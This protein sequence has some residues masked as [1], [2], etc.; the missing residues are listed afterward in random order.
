[1]KSEK[2]KVKN[3]AGRPA[4]LRLSFY[5]L[6]LTF[7]ILVVAGCVGQLPSETVV[8]PTY[9]P[10]PA[11]G[12]SDRVLVLAPHPD[13]ESLAT[14][15]M[16]RRA[17]EKKVPIRVVLMTTGDGYRRAVQV[18]FGVFEPTAEDFRRLAVMRHQE[19]LNAMKELGLTEENVI[20]LAYPDGG[21]NSMWERDWDYDKLHTGLNGAD[22]AP[23]PFAYEPNAP[24]CGANIVKDLTQIVADFKPTLILYPDPGD[25]NHDHWATGAFVEYVLD[26][27]GYQTRTATYLVHKGFDWP[28]PWA[29]APNE[30][31]LPPSGLTGLDATWMEFPLTRREESRKRQAVAKYASQ[32]RLMEPFLDS[33]VRTNE[34]FAEYSDIKVTK[35][36]RKPDFFAG[37]ALPH[38]VMRD[39]TRD[40]LIEELEGL[41]DIETVGFAYDDEQAWLALE[42]RRGI[43]PDLIYGFHLRIFTATGV[44]RV[45]VDVLNG[46]ATSPILAENSVPIEAMQ[47]QAKGNR[48]V[49]RIPAD[50]LKDCQRFLFGV[51]SLVVGH[52]RPID[53]TAYRDLLPK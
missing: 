13:D 23:Y 45:D 17:V 50:V 28:L 5:I 20:F 39:A 43:A 21:T 16:I 41:G 24:Y 42:T 51:D 49:V 6:L 29:Y 10:G 48:L 14:A 22:H 40:T 33:F 12:A 27:T 9:A 36:R 31:L 37:P 32:M 15:G 8:A 25:D 35:V 47:V 2:C 7:F 18:N 1:M 46:Q 52:V 30:R 38:R 53:R 19:S 4:F 11:V 34:L 44:R 26:L 3:G